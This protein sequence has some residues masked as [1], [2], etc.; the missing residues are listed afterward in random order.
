[1]VGDRLGG[2]SHHY[3]PLTTLDL[4]HY[5]KNDICPCPGFGN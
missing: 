5:Y 2:L 1:M 3:L 4:I